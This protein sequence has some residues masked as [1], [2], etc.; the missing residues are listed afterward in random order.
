MHLVRAEIGLAHR[1]IGGE[2]ARRCRRRRCGRSRSDSRGRRWQALPR[3][4]LDEQH[5][6]AGLAHASERLEQLVREQ[7]RQARATARRAAGSRAPTSGRGR[8]PP[9]AARRRSSCGPAAGSAPRAAGTAPSTRSRFALLGVAGAARIGAEHEVL[10]H[11]Q[12]AED[13]AALGHQRDARPRRPHAAAAATARRLPRRDRAARK[14]RDQPGDRLE[15]R[16]LAG[17]VG[18]EDD[19]DLAAADERG[20]R[21]R[22]RGACRRRR[23][24]ARA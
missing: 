4:L 3:I 23:R 9:S 7:R 18:A 2:V 6:D 16:A 13:A 24:S 5:A 15:E 19:H 21:R 1:R 14:A 8:S 12:V 10:A 17:A 22:G 20:R 11:R